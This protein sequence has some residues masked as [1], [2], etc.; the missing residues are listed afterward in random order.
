MRS[1]RQ[2]LPC[3]APARAY[4]G[5]MKATLCL[6]LL[7]AVL[8][9]AH[10]A[11]KNSSKP[12]CCRE[13]L[14][15]LKP[16]EKSI[17]RLE[18]KWTSDMGKEIKLDVLRG[19]PVVIAMFFTN[20][21]HSCPL[22]VSDL[23]SLEAGLSSRAKSKTDFV[24]VSID[25]ERDSVAALKAYREK[26]KLGEQHWMLL[27]GADRDVRELAREL[28][29]QYFPGSKTQFAHSLLV[30]V[31]NQKGEVVFQQ[32]GVSIDRTEAVKAIEKLLAKR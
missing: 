15:A 31:L 14:P 12:P 3:P 16:S 21:E 26:R 9:P 1:L 7:L 29:F 18:S 11:I 19:R 28:G 4:A 32:A 13:G 25:P 2:S 20:C 17:F 23:K 6:G 27:R 10:A 8:M 22:I 5:R 24:L 30:T